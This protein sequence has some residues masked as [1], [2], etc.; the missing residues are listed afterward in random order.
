VGRTE[1]AGEDK[2]YEIPALGDA[3][4]EVRL[5]QIS[6]EVPGRNRPVSR[7]ERA[8]DGASSV[9]SSGSIAAGTAR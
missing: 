2:R 9:M 6:L 8:T 4:F 7:H 5:D 3:V 1:Q